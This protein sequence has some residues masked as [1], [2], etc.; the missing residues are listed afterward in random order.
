V[1]LRAAPIAAALGVAALAS[2]AYADDTDGAYGRLDGDMLFLGSLG[3]GVEAGGPIFET[4]V[5]LLYLQTA[6]PYVRYTE[7]FGQDDLRIPRSLG[8]GLELR[9]LFLARYALDLEKGPPHL[10]LFAD[11]FALIAGV[12]WSAPSE[13]GPRVPPGD[14]DEVAFELEPGLELGIGLEVPILPSGNGPFVGLQ[15]LAR[16]PGRYL[17]GRSEAD[18]L[19]RGATLLFT[20]AWHQAFDANLVDL[21]DAR[22]AR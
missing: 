5:G 7:G 9:P 12:F 1:R 21:R 15:A 16:W 19:D 11:S 10:D 8:A 4:H 14:D 22:P 18:F 2:P 20:L 6:G 3:V 17:V 13:Y